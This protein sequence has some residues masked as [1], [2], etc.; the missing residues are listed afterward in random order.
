M[1][2]KNSTK[3]NMFVLP[4]GKLSLK[5]DKRVNKDIIH[6]KNRNYCFY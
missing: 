3:I 4:F 6:D 2:A 1:F 5:V